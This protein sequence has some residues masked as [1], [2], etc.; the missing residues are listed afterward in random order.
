MT[1]IVSAVDARRTMGKL[2]NIVLLRNE[3]VII[4][5]AG[6]PVARLT[7]CRPEVQAATGKLDFR[8]S[9]GLGKALWSKVNVTEYIARER[10]QWE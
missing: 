7:P 10:D 4:E 3:D 5:R 2:L 6:K 1:T 9:R 8:K